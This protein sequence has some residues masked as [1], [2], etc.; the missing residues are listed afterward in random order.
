M[1]GPSSNNF[2]IYSGLLTNTHN[3]L[4][5]T[6]HSRNVSVDCESF[7]DVTV[8]YIEFVYVVRYNIRLRYVV[9]S[10]LTATRLH[11]FD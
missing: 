8:V 10:D 7:V 2:T 11:E 4:K 9:N 6:P 5:K 3:T 1:P